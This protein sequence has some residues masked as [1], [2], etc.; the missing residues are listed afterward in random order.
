MTERDRLRLK[1][2]RLDRAASASMQAAVAFM[3]GEPDSKWH[4][5]AIVRT[6]EHDYRTLVR[7]N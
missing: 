7:G 3:M 5:Q 4:Y 1:A 2:Y 6:I